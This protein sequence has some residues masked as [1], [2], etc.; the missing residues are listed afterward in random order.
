LH[1]PDWAGDLAGRIH[2]ELY[3][4]MD[5]AALGVAYNNRAVVPD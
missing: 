2:M 5:R 1:C 4:G 3:R